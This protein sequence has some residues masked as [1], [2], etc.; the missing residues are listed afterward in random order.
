[1]NRFCSQLLFGLALC[2]SDRNDFGGV[3]HA[4]S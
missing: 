1:M 4:R 2:G 3:E